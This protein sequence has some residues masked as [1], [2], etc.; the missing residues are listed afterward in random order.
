MSE[1]VGIRMKQAKIRLSYVRL[2]RL[3]S[4]VATPKLWQ[5]R[6]GILTQLGDG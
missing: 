6:P 5:R 4:M 2:L 1:F 3:F